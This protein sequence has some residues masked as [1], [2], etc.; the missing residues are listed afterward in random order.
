MKVD[1]HL[2]AG[3]LMLAM[4]VVITGIVGFFLEDLIKIIE[5]VRTYLDSQ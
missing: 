1:E 4:L 2:I 5:S 3:L